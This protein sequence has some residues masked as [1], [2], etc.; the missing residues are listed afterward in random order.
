MVT[1]PYLTPKIPPEP[2]TA[3]KRKPARSMLESSNRS[4][5][6][7]LTTPTHMSYERVR[8]NSE[9]RASMA[10][11]A[12]SILCLIGV[13]MFASELLDRVHKYE[14]AGDSLKAREAV[15]QA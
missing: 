8:V 4:P 1:V 15:S 11:R 5:S 14:D 13:N 2:N 9:A 6:P 12:A 3:P 10:V 7:P